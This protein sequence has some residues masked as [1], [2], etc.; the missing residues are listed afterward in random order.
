MTQRVALILIT[1]FWVCMNVLLWRVEYGQREAPGGA[2]SPELVWQKILTAP[3]SSSLSIFH[4]RKKIGFC[5]WITNV[6]EELSKVKEE[7]ASPEGMI[8]RVTEY[9]LQVEGNVAIPDST[10]RARFDGQLKLNRERLWQDLHLRLNLNPAV[11]E[12][13]ALAAQGTV[14]LRAE[15]DH[16]RF[17]RVF[18]LTDLENPETLLTGLLGPMAYP[19]FRGLGLGNSLPKASSMRL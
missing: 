7:D 17:E 6:G 16:S 2:V 3:D 5:H 13:R 11:W 10:A 18:K 14:L 15:E 12:V 19:W 1:L 4:H 9:R 8:G